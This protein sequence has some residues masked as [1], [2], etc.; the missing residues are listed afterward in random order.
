MLRREQ[1]IRNIIL[2]TLFSLVFIGVGYAIISTNLQMNG[3]MTL[4]KI[5]WDVH[6]E[7]CE[8]LYNNT[9]TGTK[10]LTNNN[11]TLTYNVNLNKPGDIF[12]FTIDVVNNGNI[13]AMLSNIG[14]NGLTA[15]QQEV[16]D[17][18]VKYLD[19]S[20]PTVKDS[21]KIGEVETFVISVKTKADITNSQLNATDTNL[22]LTFSPTYAQDDNT[23][24]SRNNSLIHKLKENDSTNNFLKSVQDDYGAG[25]YYSAETTN[26]NVIMDNNCW[27]IIRI[28]GNS[29]IRMIYNGPKDNNQCLSTRS[30][31]N[32]G[33]AKYNNYNGDNAY[34]GYMY[35]STSASSYENAHKNIFDSN[36]KQIV[37]NWYQSNLDNSN[38]KNHISD[39]L[40]CSDRSITGDTTSIGF[41]TTTVS[42][43]TSRTRLDKGTSSLICSRKDDRFTV[44][45]TTTGNGKLKYPVGL[46]TSDELVETGIRWDVDSPNNFLLENYTFW[47]MSPICYY[48]GTVW[49]Q[50]WS[51]VDN[52]RINFRTV[53]SE[54]YVRP[55]INLKQGVKVISGNGTAESPYVIN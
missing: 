45:D 42:H 21:L 46:I 38:F 10:T 43:Y 30:A 50:V 52:G 51:I 54:S 18:S 1:K 27:K 32:I 37:D 35:G 16:M 3:S 6:F 2:F 17:Y 26:N 48:D 25:Y 36:I 53:N 12:E 29:S 33:L 24:I 22:T 40:F 34:V 5:T 8:E 19:G 7:N 28:N 15:A 11:T 55:V 4:N 47:T 14:N 9:V 41:G 44:N 31:F 23:S 49:A 20:T 39:T 13:D